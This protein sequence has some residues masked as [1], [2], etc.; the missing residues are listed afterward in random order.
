[1][2]ATN[3]I[4]AAYLLITGALVAI[5]RITV[6]AYP[7][8]WETTPGDVLH[9]LMAVGILVVLLAS[10]F[11]HFRGGDAPKQDLAFYGS[12]A[13]GMSFFWVWGCSTWSDTQI[14]HTAHAVWWPLVD[15]AYAV[16]AFAVSRELVR[17]SA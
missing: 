10:A 16:A 2:T 8:S 7:D 11:V 13:L 15:A 17:A 6:A 1:M 5:H 9:W 14:A 4:A 3:K 12:I